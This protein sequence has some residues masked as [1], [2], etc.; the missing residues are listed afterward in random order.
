MQALFYALN[1]PPGVDRRA[2]AGAD[3]AENTA[4]G[5]TIPKR[6]P[7]QPLTMSPTIRAGDRQPIQ[8]RKPRRASARAIRG[9][10]VVRR[11]HTSGCAVSVSF[12]PIFFPYL[13]RIFCQSF[14][15]IFFKSFAL[16]FFSVF[17]GYLLRIFIFSRR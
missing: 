8:S 7:A 11:S 10:Q 3:H 14:T 9:G 4:D 1:A 17:F 16:V 13:L 2:G 15:A 12:S 6:S 5:V